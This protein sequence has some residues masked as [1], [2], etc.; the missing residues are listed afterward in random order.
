M[1]A[2][3]GDEPGAGGVE[4][5]DE[6]IV[7]ALLNA[8]RQGVFPMGDTQT[9]AVQFYRPDVRGLIPLE[10]T[11]DGS[12]PVFHVPRTVEK[13]IRQ[14]R[15]ELRFDTAFEQVVRACAEPRPPST[16]DH[17]GEAEPGTWINETIID[18]Y[19]L[20]HRQ[21]HAHSVEAWVT[22]YSGAGVRESRLVGGIYGVCLGAAFFG[23]SMF[24]VPLA[25]RA[26][27][28]RDP[29][30]GT[31]AGQVC[32]VALVRRLRAL[33]FVLFDAQMTTAA[34]RR[35]GA[36]EVPLIEYLKMLG[37]AVGAGERWG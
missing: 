12:R 1:S 26:D 29:F 24:H 34:T 9:G 5:T 15:F 14:G 31:G 4:L 23:E 33:G 17:L 10:E 28:T 2:G 7:A 20:L 27:G 8:Y 19:T 13:L 21:G 16:E 3:R 22:A 32:L 36:F 25:R 35:F 18:W 6:Q 11:G 30:D 37:P